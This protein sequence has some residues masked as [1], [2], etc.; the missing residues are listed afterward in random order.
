MRLQAALRSVAERASDLGVLLVDYSKPRSAHAINMCKQEESRKVKRKET[1]NLNL[2][3]SL[4]HQMKPWAL[5][6]TN[7][8]GMTRESALIV[9]ETIQRSIV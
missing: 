3:M 5:G 4:I 8:K 9:K 1:L 6:R 7:I 2:K